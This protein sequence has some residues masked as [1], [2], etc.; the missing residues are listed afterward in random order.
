M[1]LSQNLILHWWK[2]HFPHQLPLQLHLLL[3][4]SG[5]VDSVV[6]TDL[7]AQSGI[8]FSILHCNF[9]LR[10]EESE[11]DEQFV[12]SLATR[13]AKAILVKKF[14]TATIVAERKSS[15]QEVARDLRYE[16]F[17]QLRGEYAEKN[18]NKDVWIA[19]AHHADDNIETVL[20]NLFRGTGLQGLTGMESF[21]GKIVRPLLNFRKEELKTYAFA[22][23]LDFIEDSS[24]TSNDYTRNYFR[25]ELIPGIKKV[26]PSVENNL[27][28]TIGRLKEADSLYKVALKK[29]L[30]S[31]IKQ[32]ENEYHI[33]VLLW[34]Q[35]TPLMTITYELIK[36]FGFSAAQ[37]VEAIKLL[38][39]TNSSY[40]SSK[41]YRLIRN[42]NWMIIAP[43][44]KEHQQLL[45]PVDI[46]DK[47]IYFAE[48]TLTLSS[49]TASVIPD[50]SKEVCIDADE[51][52]YPM[53]LR[54]W[55]QGDYFYPLGMSKKKK[56][57][58]FLGDLKLSKTE[59]EKVWVL[60]SGKKIVWVLGLRIDHRFRITHQAKKRLQLT[61]L[62]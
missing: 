10:G 54:P 7:V 42:R 62:K 58:R 6:L 14:D 45:I 5:G 57:S 27:L 35:A 13:Y 38:D 9:Q 37:T 40:I 43:L 15:V 1:P 19:V 53:L 55:K 18:K 29:L 60:E 21:R 51:L 39:A 17:E 52:Q 25:N 11:R 46:N 20:I 50:A 23:G 3:A 56:I 26:F 8:D 4:V 41:T 32:K 59:K 61:Y 24:N 48:G 16:W 47:T 30:G 28:H 36:D 2:Q 22:Q 12:R 44:A 33:P 31:M 34:K 49:T